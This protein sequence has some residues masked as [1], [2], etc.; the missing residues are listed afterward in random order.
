MPVVPNGGT[1]DATLEV[2]QL[3]GFEH[4]Q[5]IHDSSASSVYRA[6]RSS[7]GL[8]VVIKRSQGHGVPARQLTRYRNE[9]DL[10]RLL[11]CPGVVKAHDLVRHEGHIAIVLE[12][13]PGVSLRR[14][15]EASPNVPVLERLGVAIQLA[16]TVAAVHAANIIHKDISSHNVVYD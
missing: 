5:P 16:D 7:D 2:V 8:P 12:D 13:L 4:G 6:R 14:W 15:I 1:R 10:L 3:P 9:Y 11:E